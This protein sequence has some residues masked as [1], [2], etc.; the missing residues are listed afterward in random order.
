ML[1]TRRQ[2]PGVLKHPA[3]PGHISIPLRSAVLQPPQSMATPQY[4]KC[5]LVLP[6][7]QEPLEER[8]ERY[9]R[10]CEARVARLKVI[11][12]EMERDNHPNAAA[13]SRKVLRTMEETLHL[14]R[15]TLELMKGPT[16]AD[17]AAA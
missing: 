2:R 13:M 1:P 6:S 9:V 11:I 7:D 10:E 17:P 12:F 8:A 15:Q 3:R 14:S 16:P 4:E 5:G